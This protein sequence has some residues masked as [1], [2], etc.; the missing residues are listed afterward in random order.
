MFARPAPT[1]SRAD[2]DAVVADPR[3]QRDRRGRTRVVLE[4]V[5]AAGGE[6]QRGSAH[7]RE[8]RQPPHAHRGRNPS[9][10]PTGGGADVRTAARRLGAIAVAD[11]RPWR[12]ARPRGAGSRARSG[13]GRGRGPRCR[14]CRARA[15]RGAPDRR[16]RPAR[17]PQAA[18][19]AVRL[20]LVVQA[21]DRLLADVA[22]LG[23]AD[24]ALVDPRLLRDRRRGH[25]AAEPRP[26]RLDPHDLGRLL[27]DRLGSALGERAEQRRDLVARQR[28]VDA[29]VGRDGD[30]R[31]PADVVLAVGVLGPERAAEHELGRGRADH[32]D[33][34]ELVR[35]VDDLHVAAD[36][37][38]ARGARSRRRRRPP[39]CSMPNASSRRRTRMSPCMCPLR[40]SSAE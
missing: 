3:A 9:R 39:R 38:L 26:A 25:L 2:A 36:L 28:E 34:G 27:V 17:Q 40:S 21:G 13:R 37:V 29:E 18:Q 33:D 11:R 7:R 8:P 1:V 6:R 4:V 20:A 23:E 22:A 31:D 19:M 5:L 10:T 30:R 15:R 12:P 32:R 35:A 16:R 24:R 14:S